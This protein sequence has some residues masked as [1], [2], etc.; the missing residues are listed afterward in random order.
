MKA[1]FGLDSRSKLIHA[2]IVTPANVAD[3]VVLPQLLHGNETQ[4]WGDQA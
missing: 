4:V 3:S 2:A 1:H